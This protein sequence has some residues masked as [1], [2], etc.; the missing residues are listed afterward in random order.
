MG[1]YI[2]VG[3][4][5]A[6]HLFLEVFVRR[7]SLQGRDLGVVGRLDRELDEQAMWGP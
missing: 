1:A 7:L 6:G 4:E 3:S 2:I 5:I